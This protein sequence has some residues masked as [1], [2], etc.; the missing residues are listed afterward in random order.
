M[1]HIHGIHIFKMNGILEIDSTMEP[2]KKAGKDTTRTP[3]K[4]ETR[5]TEKEAQC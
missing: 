4:R 5:M 2:E 3:R 1:I